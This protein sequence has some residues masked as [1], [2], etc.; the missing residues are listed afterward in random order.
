MKSGYIYLPLVATTILA[1]MGCSKTMLQQEQAVTDVTPFAD[2]NNSG[3]LEPYENNALSQSERISD[4]ISRMTLDEK[5]LMVTGTGMNL[6]D[7]SGSTKVP[8][9]AGSTHAIPR[10]GI[11][12]IVLAD[13]P[14]GLRI[15]P[16]RPNDSNTYYATAFPIATLLSSSWDRDLLN[17]VGQAM[18][19]EVKEY[20][21]DLFLAPGMNL[22]YNPLGG[23]N[24]EYYSEDPLLSGSLA[25]SMVNGIES[26]GVGAT[27]KHFAV[28]NA[29]TSRMLLNSVVSERALREIYLRSFEITVK[30]SSPWAVMSSYNKINGVYTSQDKQLLTGLLREEWGFNGLV[31]TD[32]FGG[33]SAREQ[34]KAGNDLLMPG[35]PHER[36]DIKAAL[37]SGELAEAELD[38]NLSKILSVVFSSSSFQGYSYSNTPNLIEHAKIARKAAAEGIVLLK[39]ERE[40]LPLQSGIKTIAA[41]GNTSYDFI[42]G[43]SGSGDVNEAYTVSLFQGFSNSGLVVDSELQQN[44]ERHIRIEKAKLPKKRYFFELLPPV[45]ELQLNQAL[46]TRKAKESDI[47]VITIG[48]NSGEFQ[49]RNIAADFELTA[50]E[51]DLIKDVSAAFKQQNKKVV[52][53]LNIGNVVETASWRDQVDAIVLPWQGGQ[54]AGNAVVDVLTGKVNPSGKLPVTFPIHYQDVSSA[55][56]FPGQPQ[57]DEIV[58][59]AYLNMPRGKVTKMIHEDG[60]YVGYRYYETFNKAVAFPFG[61][62]LSYTAFQYSTPALSA[63]SFVENMTIRLDVKNIGKVSGR[64]IVQLYVS[65]P[66]DTLDKPSKELKGFAKTKLLQP[67]E[68]Q[69]LVFELKPE[70]LAS[71]STQHGAWVAAPGRYQVQLLTSS[72]ATKG[73]HISF[74]LENELRLNSVKV[75]MQPVEDFKELNSANR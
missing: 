30:E 1:V 35:R 53:I 52:L 44:Y 37:K 21:V 47:A 29:E 3:V 34:M 13:G 38:R 54:E 18:G 40:T 15:A 59:D 50:V 10:L 6:S 72:A 67:G 51:K 46:I 39:N 55:G 49:D 12:S 68:T 61:F 62:G 20:G 48:R 7:V 57:S 74:S 11:P 17:Q 65:A 31:M 9:A 28:N 71:F 23:R 5:V 2:L 43:G 45:A 26:Q 4:L 69:T 70:H 33:D 64:E 75:R 58:M 60:I 73:Q 42:S 24:F 63:P 8:G 19:N 25:A 14:A 16:T 27:I 32:W 36:D 22:Q 56:F 41:F 66:I